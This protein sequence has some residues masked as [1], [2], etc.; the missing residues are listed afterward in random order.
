MFFLSIYKALDS[1]IY[2]NY[3]NVV[4]L[5]FYLNF[6]QGN[7]S[8]FEIFL[9]ALIINSSLKKNLLSLY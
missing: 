1:N 9:I 2:K 3:A 7:D 5:S 6:K 4:V 8:S